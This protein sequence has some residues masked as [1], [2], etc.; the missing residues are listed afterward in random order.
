MGVSEK[1]RIQSRLDGTEDNKDIR[2]QMNSTETSCPESA[3]D[4]EVVGDISR[5]T[6]F[7]MLASSCCCRRRATTGLLLCLRLHVTLLLN[8][9]K[10]L[11]LL[12]LLLLRLLLLLLLLDE[13]IM[14][15]CLKVGVCYN[16]IEV[17]G[18][19]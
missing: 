13:K 10:L 6:L 11:L 15:T 8:L 7:S 18:G 5:L 9:L 16:R 17:D 3:F 12:S 2:T 14:R 4:L 1:I 19:G